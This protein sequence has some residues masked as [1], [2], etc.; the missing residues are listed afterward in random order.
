M[1]SAGK[2]N[3]IQEK[4]NVFKFTGLL[5]GGKEKISQFFHPGRNG[6]LQNRMETFSKKSQ[7]ILEEIKSLGF[8]RTMDGLERGKLS[9]FNQLNLFQ[10]LTGIVVPL[11]C[12]LVNKKFPLTAFFI[13]SLPAWVNLVVL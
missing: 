1:K 11:I 3:F 4:S 5:S 2:T 6:S 9:V 12:F 8:T 13:A 7:H 10:F